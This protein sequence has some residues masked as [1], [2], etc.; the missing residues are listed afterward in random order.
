VNICTKSITDR[1][2]D[3]QLFTSGSSSFDLTNKI[4]EPLTGRKWEY[5]LFPIS[6]EELENKHGY[7]NSEQ[8]LENRLL[9][10]F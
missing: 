6:W 8:Q 1:F 4:N 10:G 9:Y 2:K 3:V 7:L 5:Q